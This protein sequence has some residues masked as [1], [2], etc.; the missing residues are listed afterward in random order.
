MIDGFFDI[1]KMIGDFL[2]SIIH[3]LKALVEAL[4]VIVGINSFASIW[5]PS[6]IFGIFVTGVLLMIVLRIVK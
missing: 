3:G 4:N 5:M 2:S 6:F 1:V